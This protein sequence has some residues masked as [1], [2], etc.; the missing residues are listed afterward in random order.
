MIPKNRQL[1]EAQKEALSNRAG[2]AYARIKGHMLARLGKATPKKRDTSAERAYN[3]NE[4]ER[5]TFKGAGMTVREMNRK[6]QE[7]G[8]PTPISGD[9][10]ARRA[11][12]E[13]PVW[14]EGK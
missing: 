14:D 4:I 1:N 6:Y 12:G 5:G 3:N 7:T 13:K 2:S 8:N 10:L 11:K 9:A